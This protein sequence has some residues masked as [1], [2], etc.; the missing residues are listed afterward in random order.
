MFQVIEAAVGR[1]FLKYVFAK[2]Q[3]KTLCLSLILVKLQAFNPVT[4]LKGD[5]YT[6]VFLR[7]LL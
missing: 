2:L 3:E 1:C 7:I 6:G 5:S 4:L